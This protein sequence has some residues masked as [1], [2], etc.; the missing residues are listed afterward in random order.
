AAVIDGVDKLVRRSTSGA[1]RLYRLDS[2][3]TETTDRS[4]QDPSRRDELVAAWHSWQSWATAPPPDAVD[5]LVT[6]SVGGSVVLDPL[7]NDVAAGFPLDVG[8]V[9]VHV[10]PMEGTISVDGS[11]SITYQSNASGPVVDRVEYTVRDQ[12]GAVSHRAVVT[13]D[14]R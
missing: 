10:G 11:G 9:A 4:A 3:A 2:D 12:A 5:D 13:F 6:V 1:W 14:V 8:S 7:A